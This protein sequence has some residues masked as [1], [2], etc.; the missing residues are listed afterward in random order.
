VPSSACPR[1]VPRAGGDGIGRAILRTRWGSTRWPPGVFFGTAGAGTLSTPY[2]TPYTI[3]TYG[4]FIEMIIP[5][6]VVSTTKPDSID[7]M[8]IKT[9]LFARGA[10]LLKCN[11]RPLLIGR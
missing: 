8:N 4:K 7:G 11:R 10:G 2:A 1:H 9:Y 3:A 6:R 5:G